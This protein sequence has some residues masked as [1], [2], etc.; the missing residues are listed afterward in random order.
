VAADKRG[1]GSGPGRHRSRAPTPS[2]EGSPVGRDDL[3]PGLLTMVDEDPPPALSAEA[4]S[5]GSIALGGKPGPPSRRS[6]P[7]P[8]RAWLDRRGARARR[9]VRSRLDRMSS[10]SSGADRA[11]RNILLETLALFVRYE[12]TIQRRCPRPTGRPGDRRASASRRFVDQVGRQIA[13]GRQTLGAEDLEGGEAPMSELVQPKPSA[14]APC[15]A[16]PWDRRSPAALAD[17]PSSRSWSI[18]T[19]RCASTGLGEGRVDTGVRYRA[20][21]GRADHPP[22]RQRTPAPEV[23]AD[24]PIISAELPPHAEGAGERFEGVL[25]PVALGPCFS[26]RKPA[27]RLYTLD[28]YV[29]DGDAGAEVGAICSASPS[30][31]AQHPDRG[32]TSSGKTTLANALLAEMAPVDERV[33]S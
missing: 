24:A 18:P 7:T 21:A 9:P 23:H 6:S 1:D 5:D 30:P 32:G 4:L 27:E 17:P 15:C 31:T 25:P 33:S 14:A 11:R 20:R 29:V 28:D 12:L 22:G 13:S 16:P 26:I 19:A 8:S 10:A 2:N 3:L